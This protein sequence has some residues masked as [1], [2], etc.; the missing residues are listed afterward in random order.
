MVKY[1]LSWEKQGGLTVVHKTSNIVVTP[2]TERP[3]S[4]HKKHYIGVRS[5]SCWCPKGHCCYSV[6]SKLGQY[7]L[8]TCVYKMT[9]TNSNK[10]ILTLGVDLLVIAHNG[11]QTQVGGGFC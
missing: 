2:H 6:A 10:R 11:A 3:P 8:E 4:S 5:Q 9:N 7:K 1:T